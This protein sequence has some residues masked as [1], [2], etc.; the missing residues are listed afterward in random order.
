M[1]IQGDTAYVANARGHGTGPNGMNG[2]EVT[3]AQLRQGSLSVFPLPHAED[4]PALTAQVMEADGFTA[5]PAPDS[6]LPAGIRHVVLIVKE[7]RTYD[8][9]FGDIAAASNGPV[10]GAPSLARLGMHGY[11]DGKGQRL[12]LRDVEVTP[13]HHAMAAQWAFSDN[14]YADS[15]VCVDGHHWLVAPSQRLDHVLARR[16]IRRQKSFKLPAKAPGRLAFTGSNSSVHPEDAPEA[17]TSGTTWSAI[18]ISFRNYGEGFELAGIDEAPVSSRPAR[19]S[20]P[21]SPCPSRSFATRR[22]ATR[23]STRTSPI[24]TAPSSSSRK[25]PKSTSG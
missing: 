15:D 1:A 20:S 5:R 17:G 9:V 25:S 4:L 23:A 10:M 24:N 6:P 7:N 13:N 12:S 22:A 3:R 16:R 8:E 19:A 18:G 2:F 21:T 14:F 11:L